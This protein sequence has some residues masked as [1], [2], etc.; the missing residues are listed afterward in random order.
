MVLFGIPLYSCFSGNPILPETQYRSQTQ[1]FIPSSTETPGEVTGT[2]DPNI[3]LIVTPTLSPDDFY[4]K[5]CFAYN[6]EILSSTKVS[7]V[8]LSQAHKVVI[9]VF[10]SRPELL[11]HLIDED[12]RLVIYNDDTT[13]SESTAI[14]SLTTPIEPPNKGAFDPIGKLIVTWD[15][16][17]ICNLQDPDSDEGWS[18]YTVHEIAH[19]VYHV[20]ILPIQKNSSTPNLAGT[21]TSAYASSTQNWLGEG[22]SEYW[23]EAVT[24]YFGV[25]YNPYW[26]PGSNITRQIGPGDLNLYEPNIYNLIKMVFG[27]IESGQPGCPK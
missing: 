19:A 26:L 8:V 11:Q 22:R 27:E 5:M 23:A 2:L 15:D 25:Y 16:D 1:T 7:D 20:E 24:A 13:P 21:L 3:C 14:P 17:L 12:I 9:W 4:S 18:Q 6:L 10:S